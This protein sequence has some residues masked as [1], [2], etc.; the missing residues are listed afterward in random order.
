MIQ[1]SMGMKCALLVQSRTF[2]EPLHFTL[3]LACLFRTLPV[4][5]PPKFSQD[6]HCKKLNKKATVSWSANTKDNMA[7]FFGNLVHM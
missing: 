5:F 6:S 7:A 4:T 2:R 1:M 3:I